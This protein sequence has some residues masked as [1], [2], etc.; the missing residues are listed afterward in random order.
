VV[1]ATF[2]VWLLAAYAQQAPQ[3]A[4]R[5]PVVQQPNA[6][7]QKQAYKFEAEAQLVVLNVSAKDKNGNPVEG[8]KQED[9]TVTEDGKPQQVK[10]FEFQRLEENVLPEAPAAAAPAT[11]ALPEAPPP[12]KV[13]AAVQTTITP[14]K[15]GEIKYKDKRLLVLYFDFQGMPPDDQIRVQKNALNFLGTKMTGSDLVA[16]MTYAGELKVLQDFTD[17]RDAVIKIIKGLVIGQASEMG[18]VVSDDS[19]EDT[20]AAYVADD[21]EFNIFNTD[22]QLSALADAVKMLATLP[23]KKALVYFGSGVARNGI[24]NDAQLRATINAALR[25]NVSFYPVDAT[26]LVASSPVGNASVGAA[27]GNA[28]GVGGGSRGG[29][30]NLSGAAASARASDAQGLQDT[31]YALANDTGGKLFVDSNDL[32]VGIVQAQKDISSYYILGYY[33]NNSALDGKFRR[34]KVTVNSNE[35]AKLDYRSGYFASKEFKKFDSSDRE[36][37]LQ[38]ALMLGDPITDLSI[39]LETDYFRQASDRYYVPV[40]VKMPGSD[41]TLAKQKNSASTRLDFVGEIRD[42]KNQIQGSVRDFIT[43]KLSE[44]TAAQLA[45]K[46]IAYDTGFVLPPG[47]YS[48]KFLAREN[49]TG[50]MG[51]FSAKFTV[52]NLSVS[53]N[54]N[55]LPISSVV[56]SNQQEKMADTIG[57][58]GMNMRLFNFNPLVQNGQK[59]VPSVTRV[60]RKDQQLYVFLE[61]YEPT[62]SKTQPVVATLAFY[63]GNVKAFESAPVQIENGLDPNTKAVPVRFA[64]PLAKI[65]PGKYTCQVSVLDPTAQKFAF[66][67]AQMSVLQ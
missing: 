2:L 12:P 58:A 22:R 9:F 47:A 19:S 43:V 15:P 13:E 56:L 25:S 57:G 3:P 46:T 27:G 59:L 55:A 53:S 33:T 30:G 20:G 5:A 39:A 16:L 66:W 37:Q 24:D 45:K 51:T 63:R 35:T 49:E 36:R 38:E 62:A 14:A 32:A 28:A 41:F 61:A 7:L 8:L 4:P 54:V 65:E 21:T 42:S 10:V 18:N 44:Q 17:D 29:G 1:A 67:R 11:T 60:F 40:S 31:L 52:P 23:E 50:K 34:I 6:P 26:G 64:V 48:V